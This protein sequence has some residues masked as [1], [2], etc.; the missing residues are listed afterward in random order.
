M[1]REPPVELAGASQT[2]NLNP[3]SF[4]SARRGEGRRTK[5]QLRDAAPRNWRTFLLHRFFVG[6]C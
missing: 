3:V 2:L 5:F 1:L 6:L 4:R